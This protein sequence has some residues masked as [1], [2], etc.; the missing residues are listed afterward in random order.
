MVNIVG[1]ALGASY[2]VR[3][4]LQDAR[5]DVRSSIKYLVESSH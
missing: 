4:I 2:I 5:N 1:I 3:C